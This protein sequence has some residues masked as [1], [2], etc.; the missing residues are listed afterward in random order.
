MQRAARKPTIK[1]RFKVAFELAKRFPGVERS[2]SYGTPA[3]KV[4]AT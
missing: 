3:I 2:T 4:K 1:A